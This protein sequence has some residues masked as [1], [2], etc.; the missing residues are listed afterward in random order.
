MIILFKMTNLLA[1]G[2]AKRRK[3]ISD[4]SPQIP[5]PSKWWTK[6]KSA[7]FVQITTKG[8]WIGIGVMVAYWLV[9]R[10]VGPALAW[11]QLQD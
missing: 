11:W 3:E 4:N 6:E 9:V 10:F 5:A 2:E 8:A 1:M 7:Q